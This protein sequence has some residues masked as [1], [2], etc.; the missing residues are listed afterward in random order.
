MFIL[1]YV[2]DIIVTS[3][4]PHAVMSLLKKLGGEFAL[5]DLENLHYFLGIAVNPTKDGIILS[6]NKYVGDLLK[7][8]G[9]A[10]CKPVSTPLAIGEKLPAHIGTPLGSNDV[11]HYRSIVG[12]LQY[13]TLTRPDV[14]FGVNKVSQFIHAP[15]DIHWGAVKRILRYLKG[16]TK[17]GLKI[18][19]NSSL[20]VS[21]FAD[22][23]WAGCL[24]D[25]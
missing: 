5:K 17:I 7:K 9:M 16:C 18:V 19:K 24:D 4:K 14:A 2:D 12:A 11:T 22:A 23:D 3:S 13:L 8:A 20:L 25:R 15:T 6:Q 1:V 10:T 21:A